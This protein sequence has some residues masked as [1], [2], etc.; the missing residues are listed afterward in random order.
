VSTEAAK[1]LVV[2]DEPDLLQMTVENL[3]RIGFQV[4]G[5]ESLDRALNSVAE[6]NYDLVIADIFL[7]PERMGGITILEKVQES[8][9]PVILIS[10]NANMEALK[11]AINLGARFF[12][13]KPFDFE[14]LKSVVQ[15]VLNNSSDMESRIKRLSEE[16]KLTNR[17]TEIFLLLSKGL[18]NRE[19]ANATETSERT[20]KAH[21]SS[22]FKKCDVSSRAEL[23]SILLND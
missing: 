21:I 9:L 3:Q 11:K 12:L 4:T 18:S 16:K 2:E 5:A 15:D 23:L 20:V 1:I 13:E 22:I 7:G 10:G 8:S 17:E 19:I 6:S 14:S